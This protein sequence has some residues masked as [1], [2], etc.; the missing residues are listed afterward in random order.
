M[1]KLT[2]KSVAY[3]LL[4]VVQRMGLILVDVSNVTLVFLKL[5]PMSKERWD[6][7]LV[8]PH[9]YINTSSFLPGKEEHCEPMPFNS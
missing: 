9:K 4:N 6:I 5:Q 3:F 7:V 8:Y 1:Q 2:V